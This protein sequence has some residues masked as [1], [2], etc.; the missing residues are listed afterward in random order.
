MSNLDF[1]KAVTLTFPNGSIYTF[2]RGI[3][4]DS[5]GIPCNK[6]TAEH[7]Q[8]LLDFAECEAEEDSLMADDSDVLDF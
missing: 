8:N 1:D 2:I 7:M 6:G 5:N 4:C 3:W